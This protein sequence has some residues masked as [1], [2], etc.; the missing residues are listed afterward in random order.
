[1]PD[2]HIDFGELT[3]TPPKR[4]VGLGVSAVD[5]DI[6]FFQQGAQQFFAIPVRRGG[7]LPGAIQIDSESVNAFPL[8]VRQSRRALMLATRPFA[9]DGGQLIE[10]LFPLG[11]QGSSHEAVLRFHGSVATLGPFRLITGLFDLQT[12]LRRGA[13][14]FGFDHLFSLEGGL[15]AIGVKLS[16][17]ENIK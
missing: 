5:G 17:A 10:P 12:P 11:F 3:A 6:H 2:R 1:M 4:Q 16:G 15:Q 8:F 9:F 13:I 14:L 7:R